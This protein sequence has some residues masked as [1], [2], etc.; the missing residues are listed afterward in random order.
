MGMRGA[1]LIVGSEEGQR[2]IHSRDDP[3]GLRLPAACS[4]WRSKVPAQAWPAPPLY[5]AA[6]RDPAGS[7]G[8]P[9]KPPRRRLQEPPGYPSYLVFYQER[10]EQ[11]QLSPEMSF[12]GHLKLSLWERSA[13]GSRV[14]TEIL[15]P[16][17]PARVLRGTL[18][19]QDRKGSEAPGFEVQACSPSPERLPWKSTK[20]KLLSNPKTLPRQRFSKTQ[21]QTPPPPRLSKWRTFIDFK[22]KK[23]TNDLFLFRLNIYIL[24]LL[25]AISEGKGG[26]FWR[27]TVGIFLGGWSL[28]WSLF[29]WFGFKYFSCGFLCYSEVHLK[30]SGLHS[31]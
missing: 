4:Q 13:L 26:I 2:R 23:D 28:I 16:L 25:Q 29:F 21:P 18:R 5:K 20:R 10:A 22:W 17:G 31:E 11:L 19:P 6:F 14:K 1:L 12:K 30:D 9:L 24:K 3:S 8:D 27:D 7:R 15:N